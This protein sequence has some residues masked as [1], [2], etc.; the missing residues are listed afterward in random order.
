MAGAGTAE[1]YDALAGTGRTQRSVETQ[2]RTTTAG[3]RTIDLALRFGCGEPRPTD[4]VLIWVEVK[5]GSNPHEDQL[6]NYSRDLQGHGH[7]AVVLLAPQGR[8]PYTD[9]V[10]PSEVPQRSWQAVGHIVRRAADTAADPKRAFLLEELYAYM[11]DQSLTEPDRIRPEHLMALAYADAAESA[12]VGIC[13][14]VSRL[15]EQRLGRPFEVRKSRGRPAYGRDYS[16]LGASRR[17]PQASVSVGW[18]GMRATTP[19]TKRRMVDH[20]S[21]SPALPPTMT[22]VLA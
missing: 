22:S 7:R 15:V 21:S 16:R 3:R 4:D 12:L 2:A 1:V 10:V 11:D 8:L 6:Q 20:W 19:P 14:R 9:D 17:I 13:E 5:H 18:I